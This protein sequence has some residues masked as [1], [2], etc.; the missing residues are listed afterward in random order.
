MGPMEKLKQH[1]VVVTSIALTAVYGV[2]AAVYLQLAA[3]HNS[4]QTTRIS[5]YQDRLTELKEFREKYHEE[6][7]QKREA[8][9]R[10]LQLSSDLEAVQKEYAN[11]KNAG[12]E[13]KF[14]TEQVSRRGAEEELSLAKRRYKDQIVTLKSSREEL[15]AE[16]ARISLQLK[17]ALGTEKVKMTDTV[18][19]FDELLREKE[20]AVFEIQKLQRYAEE[21]AALVAELQDKLKVARD[22][23]LKLRN[24][25][26]KGRVPIASGNAVPS[27]SV[28]ILATSLRKIR[29]DYYCLV[30]LLQGVPQIK[31]GVTGAEFAHILKAAQISDDYYCS[32]AVANSARYIKA[33]ITEKDVASILESISDSYYNAYA[34][35]AL[36]KRVG[37]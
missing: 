9:L 27:T 12:W 35:K 19:A 32:V 29:D 11:L 36:M 8:E 1:P 7:K 5:E 14:H 22:N 30:A 15:A 34:A 2:V 24:L 23:N 10:N 4:I 28:K 18:K 20:Q 37:K 21:K 16:N 25:I 3:T 17:A 26:E 6:S 31:G 33:P 13:E